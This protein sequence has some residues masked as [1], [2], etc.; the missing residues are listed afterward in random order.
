MVVTLYDDNFEVEPEY[1]IVPL[2]LNEL[3]LDIERI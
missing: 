2:N 1:L 3:Y